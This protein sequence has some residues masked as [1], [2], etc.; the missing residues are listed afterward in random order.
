M[1][2]RLGFGV[3]LAPHHPIGEHPTLQLERDLELAEWLDDL[4]YDEFWVGEHHSAGWETIGSPEL[5]LAAAAMRTRRIRLG[6]GVVSIPYHHPFNV[7]ERIVQL[8][9]LSR[10]RAMLGVGP[11]ALPS[12]AVMLGIDPMT[13][14][15]RMDEGLG[16]I[17][18]LLTE[19]EPFSVKGS[20]FD[21]HDAA[22]QIR[23]LQ[24]RI[25]IACASTISP[26]G[27]KVAGKYG[28]GVLSIAS[29]SE[30]GLQALPTQWNFG[31][32]SAREHGNQLDRRDWRIVIPF[33]LSDS[34]EQALREVAD[35]LKRW[36][37]EYIVG[38]LGS[39]Q[40]HPFSDGYEAA[41]RMTDHGGAIIGTPDEAVDKI[42]KLQQLSGGFGTILA[43]AHDWTTREQQLRSYEMVARYVM[44]RVQ[45]MIRP[46]ERSAERVTAKKE[47]LM[48]AA[49]GAILKA[50]RDYNATHP[51]QK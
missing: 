27:M 17:I 49:S 25:P 23:P 9:H 13:Q 20:F 40:R 50:I 22:L 16:V 43:F 1:N 2:H 29:Y 51:R 39:P 21:L 19:D 47:E 18:R 15:E 11:G 5:F 45:G 8:D 14:R 12:D 32:T 31:E 34:R 37:N 48:N 41:K 4:Q 10:G 3:F 42:A 36:Q 44:P 38:I 33:H 30:E 35:G 28:V 46:I 24:E 7:A 26:S 6:T